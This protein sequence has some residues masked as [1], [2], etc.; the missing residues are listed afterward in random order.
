MI[1]LNFIIIDQLIN[2]KRVYLINII[3]LNLALKRKKIANNF[4][5]IEEYFLL[6]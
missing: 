1:Y 4:G 6:L 3:G 5:K 2:L